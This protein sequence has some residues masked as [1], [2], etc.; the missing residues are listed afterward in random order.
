MEWSAQ[1]KSDLAN[2]QTYAPMFRLQ[3]GSSMLTNHHFGAWEEEAG[4][5]VLEVLSHPGTATYPDMSGASAQPH[6]LGT[7][8]TAFG[9]P[10]A[11]AVGMTGKI[12]M[13]AQAIQ[14]RAF[15]YSG[16]TLSVGVSQ[17]VASHAARMPEGCLSRLQIRLDPATT[18]SGSSDWEDIWIGVFQGM[19]WNGSD[20]SLEFVDALQQ[21]KQKHT[22]ESTTTAP[23]DYYQW[24]AGCG[25]ATTLRDGWPGGTSYSGYPTLVLTVGSDD[26]ERYNLGATAKRFDGFGGDRYHCAQDTG[27]PD[28]LVQWVKTTNTSN[29]STYISYNSRGVSGTRST[30]MRCQTDG[31]DRAMP[32]FFQFGAGSPDMAVTGLDA[33]SSVTNVCVIHGT[34]ITEL[35][36]TIYLQTYGPGM[37]P[38]LFAEDWGRVSSHPESPLNLGDLSLQSSRW[39]TSFS[40]VFGVPP[41]AQR[42]PFR[43]VVTGPQTDGLTYLL[44]LFAKWG[45]FPRFKEGGWSVGFV[46]TNRTGYRPPADALIVADDIEGADYTTRPSGSA[47]GFSELQ[48]D[49]SGDA[50][51]MGATSFTGIEFTGGS[52]YYGQPQLGLLTVKTSDVAAGSE[53][54]IPGDSDDRGCWGQRFLSYFKEHLYAHWFQRNRKQCTL[55]LRGLKFA[56]LAPGDRVHV[57]IPQQPQQV[58]PW[59]PYVPAGSS[60]RHLLDSTAF[61]GSHADALGVSLSKL[62]R[63]GQVPWVVMS[64]QVDW[65]GCKVTVVLSNI[66]T[67]RGDASWYPWP[68]GTTRGTGPT[69][70]ADIQKKDD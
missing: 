59:G 23:E 41:T 65:V 27:A 36:N 34:P 45:V 55:R 37:V 10:Y 21:V 40:A 68:G 46:A 56:G 69:A 48:G 26:G 1:F 35:V 60:S 12:S 33:G 49:N 64:S 17:F 7:G 30:L 51:S 22:E 24:F 2:L 67:R 42:A 16:A 58:E 5:K 28:R 20:Y 8:T 19:K 66:D 44:K 18:E 9:Y 53:R 25:K 61:E 15:T 32:G 11:Y 47:G 6:L 29:S 70:M 4:G 63:Q 39:D 57:C 50:D 62:A 14:P 43:H 54:A 31:E 13:G 3:I 52:T 38:G